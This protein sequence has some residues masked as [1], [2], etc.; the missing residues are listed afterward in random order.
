MTERRIEPFARPFRATI[1]PPGSKSLTNRALVLAALSDGV[2]D[3]SNVL[4]ADDTL[5]MIESLARLGFHLVVEHDQ[6]RVR[7]H[8]RS[9]HVDRTSAELFCGNS[10]TTL[11]FLTA[12]CA[13]GNGTFKL[14]GVPRMRQRPVGELVSLLKNLGGRCEYLESEGFPPIQVHARTLAGGIVRFGGSLS[15]QFLSAGLQ[16]APYCRN[17]VVVDLDPDIP[18]W[19]YVA[20]TM[21]LMDEFGITC[22]LMRDPKT[23]RPT[24]IIVPQGVY[25]A[26]ELTI[27]PDAS[28]AGYFL[29][30]AAIINGAKVTIEGLGKSS[31]QGDIGLADLLHKMGADLVFGRDFIT[32]AG[33][34]T[35]HGIDVNLSDMPD[36]S[37][38]LAAV[39]C[40]ADSPTTLRGLQTLRVK[41]TDRIA[42][43][44]NE[45]TK[46]GATVKVNDDQMTICPPKQPTGAAIETYDDHR[47]A[48]SFA[49]IG[50]RLPGIVIRN[51]SCVN[52]TYPH[53]FEDLTS[54]S[55]PDKQ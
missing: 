34:G 6:R 11:R 50:T 55:A 25:H 36:A 4:F 17:E 46:L 42:A 40:F 52:K 23:Q 22:E 45:L 19:S 53:F 47:M 54:L 49:V 21:R 5:V 26:R 37:Q 2:C 43:L 24:R 18:S 29:A 27:E 35:L 16:V 32:V 7:V 48:M 38:T 3:L 20:M 14:D 51:P 12:L 1:T 9:G 28:S 8:G 44:S 15:S 39:A 13:L 10:G 30:C 41:E 31:L 33:T